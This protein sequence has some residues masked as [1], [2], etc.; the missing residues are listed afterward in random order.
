MQVLLQQYLRYLV[1]N[2]Q[3]H[4][5]VLGHA[6]IQTNSLTKVESIYPSTLGKALKDLIPT[7]FS[8]AIYSYRQGTKYYWSPAHLTAVTATRSPRLE[9]KQQTE[10]DYAQFDW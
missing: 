5:I 9:G 4:V 6:I 10:Q 3:C 8:E 1:D 7:F 2:L